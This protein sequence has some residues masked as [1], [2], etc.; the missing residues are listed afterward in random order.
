ME[1]DSEQSIERRDLST[2]EGNPGPRIAEIVAD[3]EDREM[4]EMETMYGCV[5]GILDHLFSDPPA[6]EAG[7]CVEF[8][9]E[10]YRITVEQD[11]LVELV[12]SET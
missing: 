10:G 2:D 1:D 9:Y 11:G 7:M 6:D 4:A 12:G 8:S 3:L 5:D